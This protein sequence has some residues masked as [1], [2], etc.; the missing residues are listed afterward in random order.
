[1]ARVAKVELS[2]SFN[3]KGNVVE[4]GQPWDEMLEDLAAI[5]PQALWE[6]INAAFKGKDWPTL[7]RLARKLQWYLDRGGAP[8]VIAVDPAKAPADAVLLARTACQVAL[9]WSARG[10]PV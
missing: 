4:P 7:G 1:M 3:E 5:D 6:G 8:P 2:A 10:G 9:E